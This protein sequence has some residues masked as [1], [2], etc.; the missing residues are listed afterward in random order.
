MVF[1]CQIWNKIKEFLVLFM[2]L[3]YLAYFLCFIYF[4]FLMIGFREKYFS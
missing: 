2:S 3:I 1:F 4:E